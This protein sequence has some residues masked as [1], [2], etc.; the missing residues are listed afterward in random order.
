MTVLKGARSG[1]EGPPAIKILAAY[2]A[3]SSIPAILS[4]STTRE[5]SVVAIAHIVALIA[6][7]AVVSTGRT[8]ALT[9]WLALAA[10][11]FLYAEL[12]RIAVGGVHDDVVQRWEAAVFGTSPVLWASARWPSALLSESLHAAYLSYYVIIYGP[13]IVLYVRGQLAEFRS[14]VAGLMMMFVICYIVFLVFP[15]AGP[16]YDWAPPPMV[17][18]GPVRRIAQ[19]ILAAGSSRG[20]A[21]PS[22][23]VAVAMVQAVLAFRRNIQ[24][25]L[26]LGALTSCVAIGAVYGG[27]HYG[28]DVVAGAILGMAVGLALLVARRE[29]VAG[30]FPVGPAT[31]QTVD[32]SAGDMK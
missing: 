2:L 10:I 9:D 12:P 25:S 24:T 19:R 30:P 7:A 18:D 6:V 16:R 23:H 22:S 1:S 14:T 4:W 13:P 26:L 3:I 15:V 11:P 21:F 20:T 28:V 5:S 8:G 29:L 31:M 27:F 17:F 32:E